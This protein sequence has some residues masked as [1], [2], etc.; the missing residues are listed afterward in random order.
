MFFSHTIG[1]TVPNGKVGRVTSKL[2]AGAVTPA[3]GQCTSFNYVFDLFYR[4]APSIEFLNNR[5]EGGGGV[6]KD[7]G[8]HTTQK[9]QMGRREV[10]RLT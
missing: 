1:G 2:A 10:S 5:E 9:R 6:N 7:D 4:L 3:C 8:T